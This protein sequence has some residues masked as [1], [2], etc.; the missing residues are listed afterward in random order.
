MPLTANKPKPSAKDVESDLVVLIAD[1]DVL[2]R[3][4]LSKQIGKAGYATIEAEDGQ[5]A[6]ELM[7]EEVGVA[8]LDL[9]MPKR[10]GMECLTHIRE[11]FPDTHAIMITASSDVNAAVTAMK[12]GAKEYISKPV[13]PDEL[14]V[15]IE[16]A[17]ESIGERKHHRGLTAVVSQSLPTPKF[18]KPKSNVGRELFK[19]VEKVAKLDSTILITGESGTGKTT[20]ARMIHREGPRQDKPFVAVNCASLPRDLIEAELFGHAKGAFTGAVGERPGHIEI[21]NGGTLFLDEIGDLP[22]ELQPK[23]L[24]FLQDRKIR[25]IGSTKEIEVDVRLIAATHCDL[26]RMCGEKRFRQDLFYRLNVLRLTAPAIRERSKDIPQLVNSILLRLSERQGRSVPEVTVNAMQALTNYPWPG[27]I[28]E[29]ENT[30]ER[31]IAFLDSDLI[32]VADLNL[33]AVQVTQTNQT[34]QAMDTVAAHTQTTDGS[35]SPNGGSA[36]PLAWSEAEEVKTLAEIERLAIQAALAA[37][38][39]NKARTARQLGI[40]EKSIYN[41]MRRHGMK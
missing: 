14:L 16:R 9:R 10:T 13:D 30:L 22:L 5:Q 7:H 31:T 15:L 3:R 2:T 33:A 28:R 34:N 26:E 23:L 27:N 18:E 11:H 17:F 20:I 1:D 8:L 6:V 35:D 41:K 38:A 12:E 24:T 19:Q 25:R 37:C 40:S 29:M 4:S 36:N 21:A 32:E 39:G